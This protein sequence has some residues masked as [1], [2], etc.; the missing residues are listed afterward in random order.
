MN[1]AQ[2]SHKG[3]RW[4]V[5]KV[6]SNIAL[7][8]YWGKKDESTQWPANDSLSMT[9]EHA[10]T[11]TK[12]RPLAGIDQATAQPPLDQVTIGGRTLSSLSD[13]GHKA[14]AHLRRLRELTGFKSLLEVESSNT[15][16]SECGI[17][18]SAS[19]LGALT[20]AALGA[21]TGSKNLGELEA[22]GYCRNRLAQLAR[23]GSG[24]ACRSFWGGFVAWEAGPQG[25]RQRVYPVAVDLDFKLA[26]LIVV[27]SKQPKGLSSTEGHRS[28]WTS[29]LFAPRLA[30]HRS[31]YQQMQQALKK[32]DLESMGAIMEVEALEM[33]SVMM[34]A[35]PPARYWTD[36]TSPLITWIREERL[37]GRLPAW[38]T[39]DAGP[40]V[41]VIC[42]LKD[43]PNVMAKIRARY[44]NLA[45]EHPNSRYDGVEIIQD[46]TGHGPFLGVE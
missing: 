42:D 25:D 21:W 7:L 41:H 27:L 15:F 16:P 30:S 12:A 24:S 9:L 45:Q 4:S 40:N 6:P 36:E 32:R 11:V 26:D 3:G 46:Q 17:A 18:S 13:S 22:N 39:I 8:K 19:G 44:Q 34:T 20:L 14:L 43:A 28:A 29:P 37:A 2:D 38:F 23:L 33:H 31:R 35:Q 10:L 1:Q 5:A